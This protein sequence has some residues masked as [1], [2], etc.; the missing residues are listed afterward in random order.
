MNMTIDAL[1]SVIAYFRI[2]AAR[3]KE[4]LSDV[5]HAVNGWRKTGQSIGMS[6]EEL[7]P[8]IDAFE[9]GERAAVKRHI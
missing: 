3:A 6:D 5:M 9:H 2:T 4:I 8:F 1:M 7:E